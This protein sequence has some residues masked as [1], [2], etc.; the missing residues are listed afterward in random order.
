MRLKLVEYLVNL[1]DTSFEKSD[2][3][4]V[5][6]DNGATYVD[7]DMDISIERYSSTYE[8]YTKV[9]SDTDQRYTIP[10]TTIAR[11]FCDVT[12]LAGV[13]RI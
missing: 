1:T 4:N 3:V 8:P 2:F 5:L 10:E 7:L 9:M 13:E 11:F 12:D 6:Y